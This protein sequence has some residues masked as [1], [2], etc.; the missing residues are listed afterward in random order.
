[1]R[2]SILHKIGFT[3]YIKTVYQKMIYNASKLFYF[4]LKGILT[5]LIYYCYITR[6]QS[7]EIFIF[8]KYSLA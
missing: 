8:H 2:D 4:F 3:I 7:D 1:M 6:S 5:H